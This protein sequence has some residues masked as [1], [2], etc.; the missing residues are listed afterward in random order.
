MWLCRLID[1]TSQIV[2][3][4]FKKICQS[5]EQ[6]NIRRAF[7]P[8]VCGDRLPGCVDHVCEKLLVP[9]SAFS[10]VFYI[11]PYCIVEHDFPSFPDDSFTIISLDRTE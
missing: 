7:A 3:T 5:Y 6:I 4:D 2:Q 11:I 9:F 8:L 1:A 10:L